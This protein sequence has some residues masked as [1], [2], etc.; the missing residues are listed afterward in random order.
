MVNA[1]T[2]NNLQ[3]CRNG[4]KPRR[5][6][7]VLTRGYITRR[8]TQ[9]VEM[10]A[11]TPAILFSEPRLIY[12]LVLLCELFLGRP[13]QIWGCSS[14]PVCLRVHFPA[15]LEGGKTIVVYISR[16]FTPLLLFYDSQHGLYIKHKRDTSS[17]SNC[18]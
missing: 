5:Q 11:K 9:H 4:A 18:R 1:P 7:P 3:T 6:T 15:C 14:G 13:G 10:L 8:Q 2:T 16:K 17:H 12:Q